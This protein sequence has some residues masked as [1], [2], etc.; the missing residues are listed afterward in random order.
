MCVC[1]DGILEC[2]S[3]SSSRFQRSSSRFNAPHMKLIRVSAH[4]GGPGSQRCTHSKDQGP[5]TVRERGAGS[6][7]IRLVS[8]KICRCMSIMSSVGPPSVHLL[9]IGLPHRSPKLYFFFVYG[10]QKLNR[11]SFQ[12]FLTPVAFSDRRFTTLL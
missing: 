5:F 9:Q 8:R 7:L 4:K 10:Q 1:C 12:T 3:A 2:S 11:I 6:N